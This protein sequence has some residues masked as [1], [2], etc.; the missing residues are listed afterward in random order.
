MDDVLIF[1]AEDV[2]SLLIMALIWKEKFLYQTVSGILSYGK[3]ETS[4]LKKRMILFS[5]LAF[6]FWIFWPSYVV[7][8]LT[9]QI[10]IGSIYIFISILKLHLWFMG[11]G[12][13]YTCVAAIW[14]G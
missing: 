14:R 6:V 2:F 12:L 9:P 13:I 7:W 4:Y 1:L 3:I 10:R 8:G 11:L 5:A